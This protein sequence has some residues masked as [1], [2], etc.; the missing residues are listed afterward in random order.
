MSTLFS[1]AAGP[2]YLLHHAFS[3]I[4]PRDHICYH[5]A[6]EINF[7]PV[8]DSLPSE[9][10]SK[11]RNHSTL[12]IVIIFLTF[13]REISLASA[14]SIEGT[15]TKGSNSSLAYILWRNAHTCSPRSLF[16]N[17]DNTIVCHSPKLETIQ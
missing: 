2:M 6:G 4:L 10:A 16:K 1:L 15:H 3:P 13:L 7:C 14:R 5:W 17:V 11:S 9:L 8:P 12:P